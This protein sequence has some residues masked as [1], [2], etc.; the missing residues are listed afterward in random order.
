MKVGETL[1]IFGHLDQRDQLV[2]V[3]LPQ[4]EL[5]QRVATRLGHAGR[6]HRLFDLGQISEFGR[7]KRNRVRVGLDGLV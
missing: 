2:D 1:E 4:D 5:A 3:L 7:G 6:S